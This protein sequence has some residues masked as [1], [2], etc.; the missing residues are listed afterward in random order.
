[1]GGW[2]CLP[3]LCIGKCKGGTPC[4]AGRLILPFPYEFCELSCAA[5]VV[6]SLGGVR[7]GI[8]NALHDLLFVWLST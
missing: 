1:M 5:V 8:F 2:D 4:S 3:A 7:V 6:R